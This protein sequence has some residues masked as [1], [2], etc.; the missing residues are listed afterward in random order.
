L[1]V[2]KDRVVTLLGWYFD[3]LSLVREDG[4]VFFTHHYYLADVYL[5][6]LATKGEKSRLRIFI[7]RISLTMN[8]KKTLGLNGK[9]TFSAILPFLPSRCTSIIVI[10]NPQSFNN[11][12]STRTPSN[13][14]EI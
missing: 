9:K 14:F 4:A 11:N 12:Q 3:V 7:R 1:G 8:I 2:E 6:G 13:N 5:V 10:L